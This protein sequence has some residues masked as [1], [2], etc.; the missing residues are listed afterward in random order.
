MEY[1]KVLTFVLALTFVD[2]KRDGAPTAACST[3][4]PGHN[5]RAQNSSAPY[6][7]VLSNNTYYGGERI[8]G[9]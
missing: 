8:K 7:I 6:K 3:M 1:L 9:E 2:G 4:T 5:T